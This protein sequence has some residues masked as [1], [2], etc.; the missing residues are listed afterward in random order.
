MPRRAAANNNNNNNFDLLRDGA[1]VNNPASNTMSG[2][3]FYDQASTGVIYNPYTPPTPQT[4]LHE[5]MRSFDRLFELDMRYA[6]LLAGAASMPV[7]NYTVVVR[8]DTLHGGALT[9]NDVLRCHDAAWSNVVRR[10]FLASEDGTAAHIQRGMLEL[11]QALN[12]ELKRFVVMG[13]HSRVEAGECQVVQT[14]MLS[15]HLD[16][17]WDIRATGIRLRRS[18][19]LFTVFANAVGAHVRC[20]NSMALGAGESQ[21][22]RSIQF[23]TRDRYLKDLR[24]WLKA[25]GTVDLASHLNGVDCTDYVE[26][27][28]R[29]RIVEQSTTDS[30]QRTLMAHDPRAPQGEPPNAQDGGAVITVINNNQGAQTGGGA[31][32]PPMR[33]IAAGSGLSDTTSVAPSRAGSPGLPV[34]YPPPAPAVP[35]APAMQAPVT[36]F[37][38]QARIQGQTDTILNEIRATST[39]ITAQAT[40]EFTTIGGRFTTIDNALVPLVRFTTENINQIIREQVLQGERQKD[41]ETNT[42]VILTKLVQMDDNIGALA[43]IIAALQSQI[44]HPPR[45]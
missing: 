5:M 26:Q 24:D 38:L 43:T 45:P 37:Q 12:L 20:N 36:D 11:V 44:M 1:L 27:L 7:D 35:A 9:Q 2:Q 15:Q 22:A 16:P 33:T 17:R 42:H 3:F 25:M 39:R 34:V 31:M 21:Y 29:M 10:R 40:N 14:L 8:N 19:R 28:N 30:T 6:F 13:L 23:A 41:I 4:S 18:D 32:G